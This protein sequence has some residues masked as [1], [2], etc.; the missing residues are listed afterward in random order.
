MA[1]LTSWC[2]ETHWYASNVYRCYKILIYF[3]GSWLGP[4]LQLEAALLNYPMFHLNI[5]FYMCHRAKG[6]GKHWHVF[7]ASLSA[8]APSH[9]FL[10][11]LQFGFSLLHSHLQHVHPKNRLGPH[12]VWMMLI[13]LLLIIP[14]FLKHLDTRTRLLVL[15]PTLWL[16]LPTLC[17]LSCPPLVAL[18]KLF[19]PWPQAL[20]SFH[21]IFS[22]WIFS[23][24]PV[25]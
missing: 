5:I 21:A 6:F 15:L 8:F 14:S 20:F 24:V 11:T 3:Q 4:H 12:S 10:N 13:L 22:Y 17:R 2:S 7:S 25:V 18:K 19:R 1:A 16:F 9:P 23:C